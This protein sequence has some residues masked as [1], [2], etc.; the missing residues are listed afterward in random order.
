MASLSY[1][2]LDAWWTRAQLTAPVRSRI[3]RSLAMLLENNVLLVEALAEIYAVVSHDGKKTKKPAAAMLYECRRMVSEG[4]T[5]ASAISKWVS[6]EEGALIAAGET[7]GNLREAFNDAMN[8]IEARRKIMGAVQR[9]AYPLFLVFILCYLLHI[10][11][12]E[13]VP[14]LSAAAS[15]DTWVGAAR[16][17]YLASEFVTHFGLIALAGSIGIVIAVLVSLPRLRGNLRYHLDKFPPWSVYRLV[18]GSIALQNIAVLIRSGVRLHDAL[19]LVS[20]HANPYLRERIDAAIVGTTK[21]LNL[22]RALEAAEYDFPDRE[23]VKYIRLL[24][25]RDGFDKGLF[26][27][28]EDW[29]EQATEKVAATM[30]VFFFACLFAVGIAAGVIVTATT[31][32]QTLIEQNATRQSQ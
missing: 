29:L 30:N 6:P 4:H 28:A 10:V 3:Y 12:T 14:S 27:F 5:F 22:G 19:L 1:A 26:K 31:D 11:S 24:A 7:S 15:P 25:N 17:L 13:L 23:A 16:M 20:A 21:G 8:L 32:L 18:M 2:E 9:A